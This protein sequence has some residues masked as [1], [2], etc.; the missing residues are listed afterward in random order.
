[1]IM[2]KKE[3]KVIQNC[4]VRTDILLDKCKKHI[5]ELKAFKADLED[6]LES[7][8]PELG[9]GDYGY[10]K[11]G[12][13]KAIFL[14]CSGNL[15][16]AGTEYATIKERGFNR[17]MP[18][19]DIRG[20][21]FDDLKAMAEPLEEFEFDVMKCHINKGEEWAGAIIHICGTNFTIDEAQEIYRK[22]GRL[23]AEAKRKS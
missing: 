1:M 4:I 10:S 22:L 2:D 13:P 18:L 14:E 11:D 15:I 17:T 6:Q 21:I 9:H 12:A 19:T 20:N 23:I 7:E 16:Q 3:E 5:E 8:Q